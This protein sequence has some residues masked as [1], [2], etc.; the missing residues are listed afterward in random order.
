MSSVLNP[1]DYLR[2]FRR[3]LLTLRRHAPLALALAKRELVTRYAGQ[4]IG[5]FWIIA[6]PLLMTVLFVFI[7]AFVFKTRIG[8]SSE[9]P[10]DY[11]TYMLSG[12][13]PWLTTFSMLTASTAS[14]VSNAALV[15]QFNFDLA[16]LPAKDVAIATVTWC[17]G[18]PAVLI[19]VIFSQHAAFILW[20]LLPV[21]LVLQLFAMLGLALILCS[22]TVFFRD[23]KDFVIV[24]GNIGVYII[25]VVYSPGWMPGIFRPFLYANPFSYMVWMYQDVIYFGRIEHPAS[26]VIFPVF[27]LFTFA[28]GYRIFERLKPLFGAAL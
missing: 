15:K 5:S 12:L 22:V 11:T 7:F 25:P 8:G 20:G 27:S 13:V 14:I 26:W 18:I 21:L 24:Y 10:L 16:V 1:I 28:A 4:F 6:H 23:L 17:V 3:G 2:A 19:Y 9:M